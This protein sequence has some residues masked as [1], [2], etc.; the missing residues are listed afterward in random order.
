M[1]LTVHLK[2]FTFDL[3]RGYMRKISERIQYPEFIDMAPYISVEE[4][5][6]LQGKTRYRLYGVL[7]HLGHSCNSGHYYSYVKNSD[8][9][10]YQM[11]DEMVRYLIRRH[12]YMS[13]NEEWNS[14]Y[15][16]NIAY[17]L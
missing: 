3:E 2:R 12:T 1:M 13:S 8:G 14:K 7:V 6:K 11:D 5:Q 16:L 4:K 15:L 10:W 17:C 9:Q